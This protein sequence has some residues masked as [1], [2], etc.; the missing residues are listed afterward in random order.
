[1]LIIS[2]I[3]RVGFIAGGDILYVCN[4]WGLSMSVYYLAGGVFICG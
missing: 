3:S 1:M 4:I 2:E